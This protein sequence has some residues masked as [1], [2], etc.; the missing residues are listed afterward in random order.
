MIQHVPGPR[1]GDSALLPGVN[2]NTQGQ[3]RA[4]QG[5]DHVEGELPGHAYI[6][7]QMGACG[8]LIGIFNEWVRGEI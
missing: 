2:P 6:L 1:A 4:A 5:D 7:A 3:Q 8:I